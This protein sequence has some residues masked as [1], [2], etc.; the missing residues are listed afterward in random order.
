MQEAVTYRQRAVDC[1]RIAEKMS[2]SDRKILLEIAD[3][4]ECSPFRL[5][6]RKRNASTML[7]RLELPLA[8]AQEG[9]FSSSA[10]HGFLH[11]GWSRQRPSTAGLSYAVI[12]CRGAGLGVVPTMKRYPRR[13]V[14][15]VGK[16][17][18]ISLFGKPQVRFR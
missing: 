6:A 14:D 12:L 11:M 18:P 5:S 10:V 3:A 2:E 13:L 7:A 9:V 17:V 1:I 8:A 15:D 4:W 16:T